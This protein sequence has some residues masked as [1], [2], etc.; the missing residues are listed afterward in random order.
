MSTSVEHVSHILNQDADMRRLTALH[1]LIHQ[2]LHISVVGS[3]RITCLSR[4]WCVNWTGKHCPIGSRRWDRREN[5]QV[6]TLLVF[7]EIQ[8]LAQDVYVSTS[9]TLWRHEADWCSSKASC[10][11]YNKHHY[12]LLHAKDSSTVEELSRSEASPFSSFTEVH[13]RIQRKEP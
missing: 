3:A 9:N 5:L 10:Y 11:Q 13:Q 8:T 2:L 12:R 6:S 4:S 1:Y 7:L